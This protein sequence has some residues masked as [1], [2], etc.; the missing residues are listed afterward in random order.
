[1]NRVVLLVFVLFLVGAIVHV[2][3]ARFIEPVCYTHVGMTFDERV[4]VADNRI[5]GRC[6]AGEKKP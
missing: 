1:M 4:Q 5:N 2:I 6:P 3:N